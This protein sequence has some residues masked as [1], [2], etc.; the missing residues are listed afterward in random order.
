MKFSR[1]YLKFRNEH[2]DTGLGSSNG[3]LICL[4]GLKRTLIRRQRGPTDEL[5]QPISKSQVRP[6]SLEPDWID[7]VF[8]G[9]SAS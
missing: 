3:E 6:F 7:G 9:I 5:G 1:F 2:P 4:R 8:G